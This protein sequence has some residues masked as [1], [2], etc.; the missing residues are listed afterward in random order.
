MTDTIAVLT[1]TAAVAPTETPRPANDCCRLAIADGHGT[2]P[3][4]ADAHNSTRA[5]PAGWR[6]G[7]Q[8]RSWQPGSWTDAF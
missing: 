8:S 7:L 4:P 1:K 5:V 6:A 2:A 3:L